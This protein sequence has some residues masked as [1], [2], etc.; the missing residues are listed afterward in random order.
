VKIQIKKFKDLPTGGAL[1]CIYGPSGVGK[2]VSTL[3]SLPKPCLWVPTE[4]RDNRT[5]IEVVMK[6]SPVPIKDNDIGIL[7]YTNWHELMEAMEDEKSMKPFKGVF[8]DSLSYMMGFNLEAEVT[9]DSLEERKKAAGAKMKPEDW[10][11]NDAV[12]LSQPGRGDVNN[13]VKRFLASAGRLSRSGKCVVISC[14]PENRPKVTKFGNAF[15]QAPAL[16]GGEIPKLFSG[17][18][19]YIG[20]VESK[21]NDEGVMRYPPKVDF[22]GDGSF[23]A[24][25]G[26]LGEKRSGPLR[27]NEILTW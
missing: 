10:T 3:I 8:I 23:M 9:E 2:T 20:Y 19:D 13:A 12:K 25:F 11:I 7:E 4:P 26:G 21:F 14:L 6:H 16:T 22:E 27:F 5:K 1:I 24:K 15:S 17:P 18:F